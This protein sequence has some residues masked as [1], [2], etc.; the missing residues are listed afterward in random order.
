MSISLC[1]T[2]SSSR[3]LVI[4]TWTP[5]CIRCR[6]RSKSRRAILA[7][8]T[9]VGIPWA[10]RVQLSAKPFTSSLSRELR[11]CAL[12]MLMAPTGNLAR[13]PDSVRT[14][15]TA[16]TTM[17]AKKSLS[18]PMILD[19]MLVLAALMRCSRASVSLLITRF[20]FTYRTASFMASRKPEMML[21][22]WMRC[23]TSSLPRLSSSAARMTTDVVPSP[24]SWSCKSASSHKTL[25]AGCSTSSCFRMVA[26]SFVMVTSPIWST[27]ILSSPTGPS[28]LLTMLAMATQA[29]TF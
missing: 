23:R 15:V 17:L 9:D 16:S 22:G 2:A 12:R 10:A 11:P 1:C 19:D 29:V 20:S 26:P 13:P 18:A 7:S 14:A 25:A 21:V 28:E 5:I 4:S 24:T 6:R 27:S 3:G 8:F